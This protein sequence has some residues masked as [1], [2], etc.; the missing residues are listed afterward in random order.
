MRVEPD[1]GM[2]LLECI[3]LE[4]A[5]QRVGL[6]LAAPQDLQFREPPT[7]SELYGRAS[8]E[9]LHMVPEEA[10]P[11]FMLAYMPSKAVGGH[12]SLLPRASS[13][14]IVFAMPAVNLGSQSV[15]HVF[16]LWWNDIHKAFELAAVEAQ[17]DQ[18]I[19]FG[20]DALYVWANAPFF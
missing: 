19:R 2:K 12:F 7:M 10:A 16:F 13:Y 5:P 8:L 9:G 18:K 11:Q 17:R 1:D 3:P 15:G 14:R 4:K 20:I 6:V